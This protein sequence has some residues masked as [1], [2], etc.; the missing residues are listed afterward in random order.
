MSNVV[1]AVLSWS[2]HHADWP[3]PPFWYA[4]IPSILG[5]AGVLL[6]EQ[7][8]KDGITSERWPA[9]LLERSRKLLDHSIVSALS[10]LLLVAGVAWIV[11]S[12]ARDLGGEW[13]FLF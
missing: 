1:L 10:V 12:S 7:Q 2:R 8:L 6:A 4:F 3:H 9:A 13:F 5:R 11:L